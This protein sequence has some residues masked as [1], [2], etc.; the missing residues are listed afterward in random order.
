MAKKTDLNTGK[1]AAT[2]VTKA[3]QATTQGEVDQQDARTRLWQALDTTYDQAI[4][5]SGKQYDLNRGAADRAAL[6]RGMGRSSYNLATMANID[7][8]KAQAADRLQQQKIAEYQKGL[9]DIEAQEKE[10]QRWQEQFAYQKERDKAADTQ[11]EK[12]FAYQQGRDQKGDE[13]WEKQFAYQQGR[14]TKGDEQWEKQFGYQKERDKKSDEQWQQQFGYQ[15]ER[16]QKGDEQWQKQFAYQQGRDQKGDE[17][18]QKQFEAGQ[19]QWQQQFEYQKGRDQRSDE[20]WQKQFDAQLDQWRQQFDY[21]QK[22]DSQKLAYS[23]LESILA[24]GGDPSAALLEQAGL[25]WA[26]WQSMKQQTQA[27]ATGGPSSGGKKP[28][29][30][31][32]MTQEEYEKMVRDYLS[33][34]AGGDNIFG[35]WFEQAG[36]KVREAAKQQQTVAEKTASWLESLKSK[37][38]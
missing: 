34:G 29:E 31:L 6:A 21:Q 24:A 18:W 4:E 14:D 7:T 11:W 9:G 5:E 2:D 17:Q 3:K 15:K 33:G 10:D 20:Q 30:Q 23:Y 22:S 8:Q 38:D 19:S 37:K 25:S 12:Q 13:Q 16:D 32:G 27:Q 35:P 28:W 36:S 26:D 1:V